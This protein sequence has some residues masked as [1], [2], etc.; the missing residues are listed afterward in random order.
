M[1]WASWF[2]SI[3]ATGCYGA[4]VVQL[5][6]GYILAG[7]HRVTATRENGL[8]ELPVLWVGVRCDGAVAAERESRRGDRTA[9]MAAQQADIVH[10]A[11]RYDLE[12][13][14]TATDPADCARTI[15]AGIS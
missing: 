2:D 12:V 15:A 14:T 4:V 9:G 8:T 10:E 1:T 11:V 5:S 6:T 7:N 13:D 3:D